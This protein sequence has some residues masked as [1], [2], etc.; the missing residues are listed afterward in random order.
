MNFNRRDSKRHWLIEA[1]MIVV[2]C[3]AF[4]ML[5]QC[6]GLGQGGEEGED[7][8]ENQEQVTAVES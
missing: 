3:A 7:N 6:L 8:Q 4:L 5:S 2:V 1:I